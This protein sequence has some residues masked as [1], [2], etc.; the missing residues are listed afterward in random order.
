LIAVV[1]L[2]GY[3]RIQSCV[4]DRMQEEDAEIIRHEKNIAR[5]YNDSIT[6][7][8]NRPENIAKRDSLKYVWF[9]EE[10]NYFLSQQS[11]KISNPSDALIRV[12]SLIKQW[13]IY[14]ND[15]KNKELS[16]KLLAAL[17]RRQKALYPLL[18]KQYGRDLDKSLFRNNV[19]VEVSGSTIIYTGG[20]FAS[21]ANIEDGYTAAYV[22][23]T[24]YRFKKAIFKWY[25]GQDD[26]TYYNVKSPKD[27]DVI[28]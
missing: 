24:K 15:P 25:K 16:K 28:Y 21:N 2:A 4:E 5:R 8:E 18:R 12:E 1:L 19:D 3:F 13:K 10:A 17:Q 7:I 22:M 20:L 27:S 14:K 26:Y 23:L 11:T 9:K 6:E